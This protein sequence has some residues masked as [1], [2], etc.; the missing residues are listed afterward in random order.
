[1]SAQL[2]I[3]DTSSIRTLID[4]ARDTTESSNLLDLLFS[5]NKRVVIT[6]D[7][8]QELNR[9]QG[10]TGDAY[11]D[12]LQRNHD[13]GSPQSSKI[14][15]TSYSVPDDDPRLGANRKNAG[16]FSIQDV[17]ENRNSNASI[18]SDL[19]R[20][21]GSGQDAEF[22]ILT[23]D[24]GAFFREESRTGKWRN[25]GQTGQYEVPYKGTGNFLQEL[26]ANGALSKDKAK[27]IVQNIR[28]GSFW[29]GAYSSVFKEQYPTASQIDDFDPNTAK[30]STGEA[31]ASDGGKWQP[32]RFTILS[33]ALEVMRQAGVL[34]DILSLGVTAAHAADLNAQGKVDEANKTWLR[35]MFETSGGVGG[36]AIGAAVGLAFGGPLLAIAGSIAGGYVVGAYGADFADYLYDK[37]KDVVLPGLEQF[38][39]LIDAALSD[40]EETQRKFAEAVVEGLGFDYSATQGSPD[41]DWMMARAMEQR[42]GGAGDDVILGFAARY[43]EQ[44]EVFDADQKALADEI[45]AE[46]DSLVL[47][48]DS[49][50]EPIIDRDAGVAR[51]EQ[52][53][54][55]N[56]GDGDD[57]VFALGGEGAIVKGGKGDDL[58]INLSQRGI[59]YGGEGGQARPP[60]QY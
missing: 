42:H 29:D 57:W 21:I 34:G 51:Q 20:Y 60:G 6:E 58:L 44:G 5:N 13:G 18:R 30:A 39:A 25:L 52:R 56:G 8:H 10:Q 47:A 40:D 35:Y 12:W 54:I 11:R 32:I 16:D 17:T 22:R 48:G 7:V 14:I 49:P 36:G 31:S 38:N 33:A 9:L 27:T 2:L 23:D 55:L 24:K 28:T 15:R 53:M 46:F 26:I 3:V 59:I 50:D 4:G 41:T 19:D 37:Y 43:L 45:W 1:M